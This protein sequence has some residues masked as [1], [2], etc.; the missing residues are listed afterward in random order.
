MVSGCAS[1]LKREVRYLESEIGE[2]S[3]KIST[4]KNSLRKM[5]DV[6]NGQN[7]ITPSRG[8]KPEFSCQTKEESREKGL[9]VCA[10]SY[11]GCD[12]VVAALGDKLN[13]PDQKFLTSQACEALVAKMLGEK[14]DFGSVILDG[15]IEL[16]KRKCTNGNVIESFIGCFYATSGEAMKLS[17]FS[18]CVDDKTELCY[19][20]Y[21]KWANDP[22]RKKME[23][24]NNLAIINK[25]QNNL[26][27]NMRQLTQKKN[28]LM[29]KLFG[30]K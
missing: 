30:Y 19:S 29:W 12:A 9:A 28:T 21:Q 4:A 25:E 15:S 11:K 3:E 5:P 8:P 23:C 17:M 6:Y 14:R 10:L 16:A 26:D 27:F 13:A 2:Q 22:Q 7:C 20:N 18:A 1:D 24:E